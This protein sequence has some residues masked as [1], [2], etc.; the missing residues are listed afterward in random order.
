MPYGA[1]VDIGGIEVYFTFP[2]FLGK[3]QKRKMFFP[4]VQE[5]EVKLQSFDAESNKLSL[6]LKSFI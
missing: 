4:L 5:I 1:F 2:T 6:S 3:N